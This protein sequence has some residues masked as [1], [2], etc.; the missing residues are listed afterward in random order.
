V[1]ERWRVRV[2]RGL[3]RLARNGGPEAQKKRFGESLEQSRRLALLET[4]LARLFNGLGELSLS[5]GFQVLALLLFRRAH[6]L[7]PRDP[8]PL[9]NQSRARLSLA[10]RFLLRAPSSGAVAYN[11]GLG[12]EELETLLGR[13]RLPEAR[14]VEATVLKRRIEDRLEL[15]KDIQSG[16]VKPVEVREILRGED[17]ELRPVL[18][19]KLPSLTELEKLEPARTG[20]YYRQYRE[21][22]KRN[23]ERRPGQR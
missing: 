2:E 14:Q 23:R 21:Q 11:L 20:F 18:T 19:G 1:F 6:S 3:T 8:L 13:S 5:T 22:Q 12:R 17:R 7:D 9:M 4:P 15:W 10:N 16:E